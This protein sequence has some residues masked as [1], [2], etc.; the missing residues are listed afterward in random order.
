MSLHLCLVFFFNLLGVAGI[1]GNVSGFEKWIRL[2]IVVSR[3]WEILW[4]ADREMWG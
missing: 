2:D 3:D 4:A 1:D